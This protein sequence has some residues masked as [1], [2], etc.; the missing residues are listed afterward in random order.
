MTLRENKLRL[1]LAAA[2]VP[3]FVGCVSA[4]PGIAQSVVGSDGPI[5]CGAFQRGPN[6]SWTVL[7]STTIS[8]EGVQ[9]NLP[10]GRTFAKN[11]FATA[12]R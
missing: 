8:P 11:Q 2:A 9:M 3:L 1:S 4:H 10:E 5:A 6:G 12:S 7:R